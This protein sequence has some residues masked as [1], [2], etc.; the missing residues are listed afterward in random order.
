MKN[1][2]F[3][4]FLWVLVFTL[5]LALGWVCA[6]LTKMRSVEETD[7]RWGEIIC[8]E[9]GV[10]EAHVRL[11]YMDPNAVATALNFICDTNGQSIR[12]N[13]HVFMNA[14]FTPRPPEGKGE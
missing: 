7:P 5:F 2:L 6:D 14:T 1:L 8:H 4:A 10:L 13:D 11:R 9:G 12:R 3:L